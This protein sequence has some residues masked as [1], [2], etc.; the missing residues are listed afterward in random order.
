[1][2]EP[3]VRYNDGAG[4]ERYMGVWS[5]LAGNVF[6]QWLAPQQG[7]RWIDIG[8]GNGAFTELIV[9]RCAPAEVQGI[10]PSEAQLDFARAR[11]T[12]Q[13]AEFRKGDALAVPFPDRRFDVAAM[14]LVIFFVPEPAKGVAEMARVVRPGGTVATYI[15]DMFGGGFP[16]EPMRAGMQD[17]GLKLGLPPRI[18]A[19]R[20]D[21]LRSLWTQAG[22]EAVETLPITV[23]R[24]FADFE[25]FWTVS[26]LRQ[27][28]M[29]AAL[30]PAEMERLKGLVCARLPVGAGGRITYAS[31]A[32]AVKGRVPA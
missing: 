17:M 13:V 3:Q 28:A 27:D 25:E 7:L 10:D 8:C 21:V 15:W 26:L 22:L 18:D 32:N 19:T 31:R 24:T 12:A 14:A 30:S 4:Y 6:L 1:M 2:A 29:I 5:R 16:L 9:E 20:M 23:E 11:H